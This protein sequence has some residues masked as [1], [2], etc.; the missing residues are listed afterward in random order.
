MMFVKL[1]I[2]YVG[3]F[4]TTQLM[5]NNNFIQS[6]ER[7]PA[8]ENVKCNCYTNFKKNYVNMQEKIA[9]MQANYV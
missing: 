1:F 5:M 3:T 7:Q 4:S 9:N 6:Q 2:S 8:P